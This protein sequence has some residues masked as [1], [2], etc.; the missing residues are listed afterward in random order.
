MMETLSIQSDSPRNTVLICC[1]SDP[2]PTNTIL[3]FIFH[4]TPADWRCA[5]AAEIIHTPRQYALMDTALA[6]TAVS[7]F[8][9]S[10][11]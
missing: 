8:M 6:Y 7:R 4:P 5:R 9:R 3:E 11:N 10:I 1:D 2:T